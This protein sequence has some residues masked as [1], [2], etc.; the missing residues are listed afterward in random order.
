[1]S[2]E[3]KIKDQIKENKILIYMKGSPYEPKCGF[4]AKTIQSLIDCGA[5]FSY[6][7]ILENQEIRQTLPNISDW[8]TFPQVF[9]SGELVGGCDIISEMHES[10]ELQKL[11]NE[12]VS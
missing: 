5:E 10:G 8:P 7:D 2:I 11:I 6:V 4:S 9:V 3:E 1:M 12:A